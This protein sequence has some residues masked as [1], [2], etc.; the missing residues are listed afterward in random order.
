MAKKRK[1]ATTPQDERPELAAVLD[2]MVEIVE[3]ARLTTVEKRYVAGQL[4][5]VS[6]WLR[7]PAE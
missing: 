2:E 5:M 6:R 3:R 1:T 7:G 4:R